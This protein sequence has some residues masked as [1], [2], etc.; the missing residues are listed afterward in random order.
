MYVG[1]IYSVAKIKKFAPKGAS[2]FLYFGFGVEM[3][4]YTYTPYT[5]G[6]FCR[7]KIPPKKID[8][9]FCPS[10]GC[11]LPAKPYPNYND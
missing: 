5:D 8:A 3:P 1:S 9:P 2:L 4:S 6:D 10:A 11:L 7:F